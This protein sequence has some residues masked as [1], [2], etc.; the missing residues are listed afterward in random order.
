MSTGRDNHRKNR[1]AAA[2]HSGVTDRAG[3]IER[4]ERFCIEYVKDF[5][6]TQAAIRAGYS[7][8]AAKQQGCRLLTYA[9]V[10]RRLMELKAAVVSVSGLTVERIARRLEVL[11]FGD[12]RQLYDANGQLKPIHE[13]SEESAALIAGLETD[14][15]YEG[16]SYRRA[17]KEA[18]Q[19]EMF[20]ESGALAQKK[21]SE[22]VV[23][24]KVKLRSQERS[25]DLAMA[26]LG[27]HKSVKPGEGAFSL[28]IQT[29][30]GKAAR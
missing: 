10:Q 18:G 26:Y 2:R 17:A 25:L 22:V 9:T 14:E 7:K 13:L 27:M 11:C 21:Q 24:R 28:T 19:R 8:K 5:N 16:E 3:A 15:V 30:D 6:G 20:D 29:S 12:I 1:L 23:T 4:R